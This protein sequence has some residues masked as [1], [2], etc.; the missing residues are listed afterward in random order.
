[1]RIFLLVIKFGL[2]AILYLFIIRIFYFILSDLRRVSCKAGKYGAGQ[3]AMAGAKLV[4]T[5]SND[6]SISRGEV[7]NMHSETLL[8][9]G[10]HNQIIITDPFVSHDHAK[11][12]FQQGDFFLED[13]GSINGTY[14]NGVRVTGSERLTHGD[15][16]R[17]AGVTFKFVRWE[18]ELE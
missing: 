10:H 14:I 7:V 16:I 18:Y 13:L 12:I 15:T 8:G 2:L 1:M 4:V 5:E 17:I 9:R 3:Q 6:P 11:I